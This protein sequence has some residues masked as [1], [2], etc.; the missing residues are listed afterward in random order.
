M[1]SK[2]KLLAMDLEGVLVPEIWIAV[3][4]KTR[5]DN[6]KLKHEIFPIMTS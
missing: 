5:I 2:P 6:L 4:E 1:D 3:S